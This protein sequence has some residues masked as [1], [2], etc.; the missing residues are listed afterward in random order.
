MCGGEGSLRIEPA[1]NGYIVHAYTPGKGEKPGVHHDLIASDHGHAL[2]L[3]APH[4]KAMGKRKGKEKLTVEGAY[5]GG[6]AKGKSKRGQKKASAR[7]KD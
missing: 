7:K 4:V 3:A 1:D 6:K 5:L 2:R